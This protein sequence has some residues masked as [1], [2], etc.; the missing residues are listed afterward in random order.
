MA[1]RSGISSIAQPVTTWEAASYASPHSCAVA[2]R[3]AASDYSIG[4]VVKDFSGRF[5]SVVYSVYDGTNTVVLL[6]DDICFS[7]MTMIGRVTRILG[8]DACTGGTP[9]SGGYHA[10]G[11]EPASA[12]DGK[13]D[14]RFLSSQADTGV[15]GYA[16]LGYTFSVAKKVRWFSIVQ[17]NYPAGLSAA[18]SRAYLQ[19][20]DGSEWVGAP[21]Y[22]YTLNT[23]PCLPDFHVQAAHNHASTQWRLLAAS[24]VATGMKWGVVELQMGE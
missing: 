24:A 1:S 9:I 10:T 22:D 16:Y 17:A 5:A 14:T 13:L 15:S 20:Y 18:I 6:S 21:T 3:N 19:Y 4:T 12:F 11:Y 2:G 7:G 8:T 23:I